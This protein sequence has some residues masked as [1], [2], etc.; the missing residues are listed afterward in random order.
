MLASAAHLERSGIRILRP[1]PAAA[2]A[3]ADV[4][5]VIDAVF[6]RPLS[7]Y[8]AMAAPAYYEVVL[9]AQNRVNAGGFVARFVDAER[10]SLGMTLGPGEM[11]AQRITYLRAVR[12][13]VHV[14]EDNVGFHRESFFSP[15]LAR[16]FNIWVPLR[17]VTPENALQYV[18]ESQTIP[19]RDI[20]T[21]NLGEA[22]SRVARFSAG[23]RVGMLYDEKRI[24]G[25]VD[26]SRTV[27]LVVPLGSYALFDANLI[28]GAG[29]NQGV[30]IRFSLDFRVITA[31]E[32]RQNA[33]NF[34]AGGTY[35][36]VVPRREPMV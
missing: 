26:L 17:G 3:L 27:R 31:S 1:T 11:S 6:D 34:A 24:V 18:P 2:A 23:H 10:D 21:V 15:D 32:V 14:G 7:D 5:T 28:H 33:D 25:G 12:P 36:D 9:E 20:A 30:D 29:V 22:N 19:D 35:F 8:V 16:A 13:A 4:Q